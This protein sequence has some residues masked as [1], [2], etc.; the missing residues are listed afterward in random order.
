MLERGEVRLEPNHHHQ[1]VGPMAGTI[2]PSLPVWVVENRSFGNRGFCRQVEARQQFGE[3][4]QEALEGLRRWRD[5]WAPTL[6]EALAQ[7]GS[8][9]LNPIITQALQMGDEL[10]NRNSASSSLFANRMA[11]AILQAAEHQAVGVWV[12]HDFVDGAHHD[13]LRPALHSDGPPRR[14][15]A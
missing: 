10:H 12:R 6:R 1:A 14:A 8:L 2:S 7:I 15:S 5:L 11:I 4:S 3:Y 13:L 9:D